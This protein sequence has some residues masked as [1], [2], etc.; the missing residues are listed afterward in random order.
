MHAFSYCWENKL[1]T[2]CISFFFFSHEGKHSSLSYICCCPWCQIPCRFFPTSASTSEKKVACNVDWEALQPKIGTNYKVCPRQQKVPFA[3][4]EAQQQLEPYLA[5]RQSSAWLA[6]RTDNPR[7]SDLT[8]TQG[9]QAPAKRQESPH[10]PFRYHRVK[11]KKRE[12][13]MKGKRANVKPARS[14]L[15]FSDVFSFFFFARL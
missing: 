8:V 4:A 12:K 2:Q 11:K 10:F 9:V 6:P 1:G 7:F 3:W 13:K 15:F 14:G 5:V